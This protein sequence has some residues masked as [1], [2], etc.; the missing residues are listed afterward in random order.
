MDGGSELGAKLKVL[1]IGASRVLAPLVA[2]ELSRGHDVVAVTRD[3]ENVPEASG[4]CGTL[5]VVVADVKTNL[6]AAAVSAAGPFDVAVF[7]GPAL[8]ISLVDVLAEG[9]RGRV[10]LLCSSAIARPLAGP[11]NK[12]FEA[13]RPRSGDAVVILGWTGQR[14][15]PRWHSP[16]EISAAAADIL[17]SGEDF[18]M[19]RVRPWD[20]RP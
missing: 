12:V 13:A 17:A 18:V 16:E 5:R 4:S 19:G 3:G 2:N 6:G 20:E 7:Y 11:L 8:V 1:V 9:V 14:E 10:V 15:S